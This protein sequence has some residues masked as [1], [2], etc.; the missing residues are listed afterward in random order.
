MA[1]G[2]VAEQ[3]KVAHR[4]ARDRALIDEDATLSQPLAHFR[5]AQTIPHVPVDRQGDDVV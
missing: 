4:R 2:N 3:Q 5:V 1:M